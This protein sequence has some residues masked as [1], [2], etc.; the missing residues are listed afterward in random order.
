MH[1][2]QSRTLTYLR[3]H[4]PSDE[5]TVN[6][7]FVSAFI[8]V[9]G[10]LQPHAAFL[11][12]FLIEKADNDFLLLQTVSDLLLAEFGNG[13]ELET[14]VQLFEYVVSPADRI[15]TGAVYTPK[16]VRSAIISSCLG[17]KTDDELKNLRVADISCG[18]GGFLM[19]VAQLIHQRT[20]KTYAEIYR[21]NIFGID[22]QSYAILL[23]LNL[24]W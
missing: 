12:D 16:R 3:R 1:F 7:L 8:A 17:D 19:D 10:I 20:G 15:V 6:R 9:R 21:D 14:L 22:V 5:R 11:S 4:A 2:S 24:P 18:C 13:I 23:V